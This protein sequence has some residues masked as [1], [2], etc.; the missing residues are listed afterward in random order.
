MNIS[1]PISDMLV[2]IKNAGRVFHPAVKLQSSKIKVAIAKILKQEGF[3]LDYKIVDELNNKHSLIIELKYHEKKHVIDNFKRVSK[4]SC[5]V[6]S[7]ASNIPIV[8]SGFGIVIMSTPAGV[9]T[10]KDAVRQNVGGEVLCY[11]Y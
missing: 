7:N 1:D 2:Q 6:Y 8:R 5:R 11:V 4:P 3:I 10:G 9:V